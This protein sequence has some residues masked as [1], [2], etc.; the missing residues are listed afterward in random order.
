MTPTSLKDALDFYCIFVIHETR[1]TPVVL[2]FI[3]SLPLQSFYMV[4]FS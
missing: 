3:F 2:L 1:A 4:D